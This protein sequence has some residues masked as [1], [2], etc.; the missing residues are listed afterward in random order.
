[1]LTTE[2]PCTRC[3]KKGIGEACVEGVRKKAKYLLEGDERGE[4]ED[5][6]FWRLSER[7]SGYHL[8][9]PAADSRATT[10]GRRAI[11]VLRSVIHLAPFSF[12]HSNALY[13]RPCTL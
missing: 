8:G 4:C 10:I 12:S 3:V 9:S 5:L 2:R 11:I 1:M 7:D 13:T 6:S